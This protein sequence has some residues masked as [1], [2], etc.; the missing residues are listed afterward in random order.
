MERATRFEPATYSLARSRSTTE[1][2]PLAETKV[3]PRILHKVQF[4]RSFFSFIRSNM[5]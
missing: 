3:Y 4:C 5:V 1:L 2:C